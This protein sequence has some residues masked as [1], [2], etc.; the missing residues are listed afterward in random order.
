[1]FAAASARL[2]E[3]E[4][5]PV[6]AGQS[7]DHQFAGHGRRPLLRR[8]RSFVR[9]DPGMLP[10]L[11]GTSQSDYR[12]I[13]TTK[14]RSLGCGKGNFRFR[15][16]SAFNFLLPLQEVDKYIKRLTT[17]FGSFVFPECKTP[18]DPFRDEEQL[19]LMIPN[20]RS[21]TNALIA[22]KC[23]SNSDLTY[24]IVKTA[25]NNLSIVKKNDTSVQH[26]PADG[27]SEKAAQS[28]ESKHGKNAAADA[29]SDESK[30][31]VMKRD[32]DP[33]RADGR[34]DSVI[35]KR[36]AGSPLSVEASVTEN[37][38]KMKFLANH[39]RT[40]ASSAAKDCS[41]G[42]S[43]KSIG[44]SAHVRSNDSE[45]SKMEFQ[46][47][48]ERQSSSSK[49]SDTPTKDATIESTSKEDRI[50]A[51]VKKL[52]K[53]QAFVST[54]DSSKGKFT[55]SVTAVASNKKTEQEQPCNETGS[56]ANDVG[57]QQQPMIV[58]PQRTDS[59]VEPKRKSREGDDNLLVPMHDRSSNRETTD[60]KKDLQLAAITSS[61]QG[62]MSGS[63]V[64]SATGSLDDL[65]IKSEPV[66]G[67]EMPNDDSCDR[68]LS[69]FDSRSPN[70]SSTPENHFSK[71][72]VKNINSMT[73]PV[74]QGPLNQLAVRR[75]VGN[76]SILRPELVRQRFKRSMMSVKRP[77][78][79]NV[80]TSITS[81]MQRLQ[82]Q[83]Q[84]QQ[85]S[86]SQLKPTLQNMVCIPM[87]RSNFQRIDS[88]RL[89]NVRGSTTVAHAKSHPPPLTVVSS[90][91]TITVLP[92]DL[93]SHPK[94]ITANTTISTAGGGPPPLSLTTPPLTASEQSIKSTDNLTSV[95]TDMLKH[96]E[97]K[98]TPIKPIGPLR[99]DGSQ[100]TSETGH[101]SE[102]L[103]DN[104]HKFADFFRSVLEVTLADIASMG[105]SEAR[106]QLLELELEQ[107]KVAHAKEIADLKSNTGMIL[108]EMKK[109]FE[110]EK[111]KLINETRR[112]C[113]LDR[114]RAVEDTKKRQ[115]CANCGKEAKFY[116]CWNTSYCDYP[117]QQ[118][119]WPR[120]MT[121]CSQTEDVNG[122]K[123]GA[124]F[125][126]VQF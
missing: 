42:E 45:Q 112:Q 36:K 99:Y 54:N 92:K 72:S 22:K 79:P 93:I 70:G 124:S 53:L 2:G 74:E 73:M 65:V 43:S 19:E 64:Q 46:K 94:A 59:V 103:R 102:M 89:G 52:D 8:S 76:K 121:N 61:R 57:D 13:E 111:T 12:Q 15:L 106:I 116:C 77:G 117:C 10:V 5:L 17:K 62:S 69:S 39:R 56:V 108:N 47:R 85:Q 30:Y 49:S 21:H 90:T 95:L 68:M 84:Q 83:Q 25:D 101:Y 32:K 126:V 118:Q 67:D 14:H 91:P 37:R 29:S 41:N 113:E 96:K 60:E 20:Y 11:E 3:T 120:H 75:F 33:S 109:N 80:T 71:I 115:W 4:R 50:L 7:D 123:V 48:G 66:S 24:K 63:S 51:V 28:A 27:S 107:C 87:D 34:V 98:L 104:S 35:L 82:Q 1:M 105:C 110:T 125:V 81:N 6:L 38:K 16:Q 55:D 86:N 23:T 31:R 44:R 100:L 9:A 119:H 18:F 58:I 114:I 122:G 88:I 26:P 97:P 78:Q 40:S